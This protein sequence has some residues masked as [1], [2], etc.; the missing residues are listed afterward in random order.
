MKVLLLQPPVQDFYDTDIRVQPIGLAYLKASINHHL[1]GIEVLIKDYH[2]GWGRLTI[3]VPNELDYLKDF[4]CCQDKSPFSAFYNF[5]HYGAEYEI[6]AEDVLNE[7]P[8][9]V[10]I[11]SLFSPYYREVLETAKAIKNKINVPVVIGGSHVSADPM[12]ILTHP[13]VDYIIRGEGERALVQLLD[14]WQNSKDFSKVPNLGY[15]VDS[16]PIL[17]ALEENYPVNELPVPDFSDFKL[18]KYQFKK[19]PFCFIM[20]SRDCPYHCSFCSVHLTFGPKYRRRSN[21]AIIEEIKFRYAQGYRVIDFED[22]NLTHDSEQMKLLCLELIGLFPE[23]DVT[24]LAMN[25]IAYQNLTKEILSLMKQ[26]G[27]RDLNISLV[28]TDENIMLSCNRPH[29]VSKYKEVVDHAFELGFN[30]VSYHIYGLPGDNLDSMIQTLIFNSRLPVLLG[31]SPFYM[32]PN[33]PVSRQFPKLHDEDIIR[34]RLTALGLETDNFKREDI[35]TLF[36]S[37]RLIN[38][39]KG[40]KFSSDIVSLTDLIKNPEYSSSRILSGLDILGH[41]LK[42]KVLYAATTE[43][44]KILPKFRIELFFDIWK[45]LDFIMTRDGKRI[46][47]EDV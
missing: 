17:N 46:V 13:A 22:D 18:K 1:Q 19:K 45:L 40:L 29:S 25:G 27:F 47:I 36:I 28:S 14:V 6:I 21:R 43:G 31:A 37:T 2:H 4:Y 3:A 10:G 42:K 16:K 11:S 44:Y 15:K 5:Y 8:D 12:S 38:F 32:T 24:F 26:A 20:T 9:F 39:L 34:A 23:R 33:M 35:Y 30:I 41:L 7:K